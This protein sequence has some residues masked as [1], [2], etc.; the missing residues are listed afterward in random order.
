MIV[1]LE[2]QHCHTPLE[3]NADE[4]DPATTALPCPA[5]KGNVDVRQPAPNAPNERTSQPIGSGRAS[6]AAPRALTNILLALLLLSIL[7]LLTVAIL[8]YADQ[9]SATRAT[10]EYRAFHYTASYW[11]DR[12]DG[13]A[14]QSVFKWTDMD[15]PS[16]RMDTLYGPETALSF[17]AMDGW[18]FV[19]TDGSTWILKRREDLPHHHWGFI[20]TSEEAKDQK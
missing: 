11:R 6:G 12:E 2:C 14:Y 13:K 18:Q 19:W 15:Q 16:T 4:L 3:I 5:C 10:W 7:G 8:N 20:V 17:A 9:R 1:K